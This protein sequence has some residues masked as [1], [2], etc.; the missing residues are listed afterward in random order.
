MGVTVSR[1]VASSFARCSGS[2]VLSCRYVSSFAP[3]SRYKADAAYVSASTAE[4]PSRSAS[5]MMSTSH[6]APLAMAPV[7]LLAP[8]WGQLARAYAMVPGPWGPKYT[9][10]PRVSMSRL[11][12]RPNAYAVGEWMV[13]QTGWDG[14]GWSGT[15]WDGVGRVS[16]RAARGAKERAWPQRWRWRPAAHW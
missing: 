5:V 7:P 3:L 13:A 11:S 16:G 4:R 10:R 2:G 9:V 1:C 14:V 15:E 12:N 6:S 8:S